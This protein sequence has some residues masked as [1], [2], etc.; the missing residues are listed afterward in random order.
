MART[1]SKVCKTL[2]KRSGQETIVQMTARQERLFD[3]LVG[4]LGNPVQI[5]E[6]LSTMDVSVANLRVTKKQ[7]QELVDGYYTITSKWGQSYTM[8]QM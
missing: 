1:E 4:N 2:T 7:V 6:I 3:L 8:H 5:S